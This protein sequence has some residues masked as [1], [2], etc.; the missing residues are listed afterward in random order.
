M[1]ATIWLFC[2]SLCMTVFSP[3]GHADDSQIPLP[4]QMMVDIKPGLVW[5]GTITFKEIGSA[6]K[7]VEKSDGTKID[8]FRLDHTINATIVIKACGSLG[9]MKTSS[10]TKN[11][12]DTY[13][14]RGHRK[15]PTLRCQE[16][17]EDGHSASTHQKKFDEEIH[18]ETINIT[19]YNA[20]VP[21]SERRIKKKPYAGVGLMP[22]PPNNYILNAECD[23][24]T[25]IDSKMKTEKRYA[26]TGKSKI[27][28][29]KTITVPFGQK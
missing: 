28:S 13:Q 3:S 19:I 26:C 1:K 12:K 29:W 5:E 16:K 23:V 17:D 27:S 15:I 21:S 22:V 18:E 20:T 11:R 8:T 4:L 10:V 7:D 9:H 6:H 2:L 25:Q 24:F 14:K